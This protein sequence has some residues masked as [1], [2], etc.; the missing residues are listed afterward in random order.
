MTLAIN[1][2]FASAKANGADPT[3]VQPSNWNDTHNITCAGNSVLGNST[4]SAGAVAEI[5]AGALGVSILATGVIADLIAA[6]VPIAT[7]GDIK[8]TMKTTA[9]AGWLMLDNGTLGPTGSGASHAD[10][11]TQALYTLLWNNVSDTYCQVTGGRGGSAAADWTA[12]KPISLPKSN[13][14]AI[15]LTGLPQTG[16]VYGPWN[17]GQYFGEEEHTLT[18]LEMPTHTHGGGVT[19]GQSEDHTH[20]VPG[21]AASTFNGVQYVSGAGANNVAGQTTSGTS[22]DHTHGIAAEG[23]G[24]AHNNVQPTIRFNAMIKL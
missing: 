4:G 15:G 8:L 2:K 14:M 17:L 6:G 9:D 23:G 20:T 10:N 7:T 16:S 22:N 3:Q 12:A 24:E 1:H 21:G 13:G 11:S 18:D 5:P 19:G